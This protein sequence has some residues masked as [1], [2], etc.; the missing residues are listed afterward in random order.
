MSHNV[1]EIQD[2]GFDQ[3]IANGVVLADFWAPWCG[4]CRMQGPILEQVSADIGGAASIIKINVD[5]SPDTAGRFGVRSIPTLILFKDGKPVTQFV[6][7]QRKEAIISAIKSCVT[8]A[9]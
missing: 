7:L 6:G 1:T 3:A 9:N 8:A 5:E 2:N 4:P